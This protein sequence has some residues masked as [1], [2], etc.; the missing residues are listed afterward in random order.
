MKRATKLA[1]QRSTRSPV[2][3]H[4]DRKKTR[5]NHTLAAQHWTIERP[6][7]AMNVD[8]SLDDYKYSPVFALTIRVGA[9]SV[10]DVPSGIAKRR[11]LLQNGGL[12]DLSFFPRNRAEKGATRTKDSTVLAGPV[13]T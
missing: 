8:K 7:S 2:A 1:P 11:R 13:R 9:D 12:G 3:T 5:E 4:F 10:G 6:L